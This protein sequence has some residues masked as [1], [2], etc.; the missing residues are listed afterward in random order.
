MAR[1]K[2]ITVSIPAEMH[3]KAKELSVKLLG[4]ENLSAYVAHLITE[5][6]RQLEKEK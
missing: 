3:E 4:K 2:I 5:K 1:S 6:L